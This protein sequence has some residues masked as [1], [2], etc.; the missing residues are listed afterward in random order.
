MSS[1]RTALRLPYGRCLTSSRMKANTTLYIL[2]LDATRIVRTSYDRCRCVCVASLRHMNC[3]SSLEIWDR[4]FES[5]S[6]HGC[7]CAY[8]LCVV[9]GLATGPSHVRGVLPP[10]YGIKKLK[11][12]LPRSNKNDCRGTER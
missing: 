1:A 10:V 8:I 12:N 11:K 3:L 2:L 5:H 6:R 4:G 7:L 9:S